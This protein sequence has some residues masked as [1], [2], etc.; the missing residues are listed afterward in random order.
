MQAVVGIFANIQEARRAGQ[1]VFRAVPAVRVRLVSPS[2]SDDEIDTLP[3]DEGEQPG[4]GAAV[5]GVVGGAVGAALASLL[6]PPVGATAVV[7]IAGGALLGV[8]SG[9]LAGE[10]L[11]ATLSLG[12][13]RDELLVYQEAVRRGRS[14]VVVVSETVEEADAVRETLAAAGAQSVDAAREDWSVGL[15]NPDGD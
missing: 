6:A 2:A 1:D 13:P 4:M 3:T 10:A 7:G 5:G 14:L 12:V 15:R 9:A 8:G 11:E